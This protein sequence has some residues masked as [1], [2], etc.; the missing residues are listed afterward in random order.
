MLVKKLLPKW[1][2]NWKLKIGLSE[3]NKTPWGT[4]K[5]LWMLS[6]WKLS[7]ERQGIFKSDGTVMNSHWHFIAFQT[8]KEHVVKSGLSITKNATAPTQKHYFRNIQW[9]TTSNPVEINQT[10]LPSFWNKAIVRDWFRF[11]IVICPPL[12]SMQSHVSLV[13]SLT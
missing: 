1:I 11:S 4:T 6:H 9:N 10:T 3:E 12:T 13:S 8:S 2:S 5:H 7:Y